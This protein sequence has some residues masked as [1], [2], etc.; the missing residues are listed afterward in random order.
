MQVT[1]QPPVSSLSEGT[2]GFF[3]FVFFPMVTF[4]PRDFQKLVGL[5]VCFVLLLCMTLLPTETPKS[6]HT[7]NP[8]Q[9]AERAVGFLMVDRR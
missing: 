1:S 6:Q 7:A 2:V 8:I 4:S 5:F 9:T 3:V